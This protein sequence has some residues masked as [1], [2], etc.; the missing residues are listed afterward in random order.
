VRFY[1]DWI[2]RLIARVKE[3]GQF[4][5]AARR[6]EVATLFERALRMYRGIESTAAP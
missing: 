2:E 5:T 6:E 4:S 3:R 1:I